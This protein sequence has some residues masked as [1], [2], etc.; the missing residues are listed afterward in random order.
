ML[1]SKIV[2]HYLWRRIIKIKKLEFLKNFFG[3]NFLF[4]EIMDKGWCCIIVQINLD[5]WDKVCIFV[6][7]ESLWGFR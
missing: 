3:N 7:K 6:P 4:R 2:V 5:I 1:K